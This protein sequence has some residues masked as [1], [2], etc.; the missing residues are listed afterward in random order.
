MT[1]QESGSRSQGNPGKMWH[2]VVIFLVCKLSEE[3]IVPADVA[4]EE[5]EDSVVSSEYR[6]LQRRSF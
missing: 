4:D 1:D 6:S 3:D 5:E 2:L